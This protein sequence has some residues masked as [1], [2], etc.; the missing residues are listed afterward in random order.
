MSKKNNTEQKRISVTEVFFNDGQVEGLPKNPRF[1]KNEK[2]RQLVQSIKEFPEM[3][4]LRP[5]VVDENMVVLG[6]NMRLKA[7][8][9]AGLQS[10]GSIQEFTIVFGLGI[11]SNPSQMVSTIVSHYSTNGKVCQKTFL[12]LILTKV[13]EQ[14]RE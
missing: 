12:M 10:L 11:Q 2:F 4:D 9:E 7:S 6:G 1:I 8:I 13:N 14:V 3:L 5:I